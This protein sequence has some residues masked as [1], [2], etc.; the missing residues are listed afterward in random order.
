MFT[1]DKR[2]EGQVWD[3]EQQIRLEPGNKKN[4]KKQTHVFF[5]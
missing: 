2:L 3:I 4:K 5:F 1:W